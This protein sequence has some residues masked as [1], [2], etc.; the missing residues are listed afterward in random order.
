MEHGAVAGLSCESFPPFRLEGM[1][2]AYVRA[3]VGG[4]RLPTGSVGLWFGMRGSRSGADRAARS[5][6][7]LRGDA[8]AVLAGDL[9]GSEA[10]KSSVRACVC[11]CE[12]ERE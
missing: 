3:V 12:R 10:Q 5:A 2:P 4:H 8:P 9:G 6:R 1:G 7:S 11:V